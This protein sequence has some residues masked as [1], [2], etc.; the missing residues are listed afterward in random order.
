MNREKAEGILTTIKADLTRHD[1]SNWTNITA[2]PGFEYRD[3]SS[4][5]GFGEPKVKEHEGQVINCGTTACFAGHAGFI[6]APVGT[7]FYKESMLIPG[8][9]LISYEDFADQELELTS[10][11]TTYLFSG[12][13][14]FE[15]LQEYIEAT[16]D[17]QSDILSDMYD[18]D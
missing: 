8:K 18:E 2:T 1:Q 4:Y 3:G 10:S 13:R 11:E 17:Q 15:E 14:T 5:P 12:H 16:D 7:K 9:A 6:F